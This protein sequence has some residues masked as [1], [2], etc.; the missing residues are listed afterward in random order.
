MTTIN[1][2]RTRHEQD[3]VIAADIMK[4]MQTDKVRFVIYKNKKIAGYLKEKKIG[5]GTH[6]TYLYEKCKKNDAS[7]FN[8]NASMIRKFVRASNLWCAESYFLDME[9]CSCY[10]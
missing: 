3:C 7:I 2:Y 9:P 10:E 1:K 4:D 5:Q 8:V 6:T